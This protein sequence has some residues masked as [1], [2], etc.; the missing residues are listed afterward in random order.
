MRKVGNLSYYIADDRLATYPTASS[1]DRLATYPTLQPL[2]AST[3]FFG[4][5]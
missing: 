3:L 4:S 2:F 1:G 5:E